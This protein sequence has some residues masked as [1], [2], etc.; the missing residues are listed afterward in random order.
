[1]LREN[2]ELRERFERFVIVLL[3]YEEERKKQS[4]FIEEK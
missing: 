2:L 4:D 3:I 1:M